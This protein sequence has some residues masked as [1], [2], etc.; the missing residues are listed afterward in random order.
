M[1]HTGRM[2][3]V[4]VLFLEND[5]KIVKIIR[6]TDASLIPCYDIILRM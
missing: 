5:M 1:I 4:P 3:S 2:D 6:V